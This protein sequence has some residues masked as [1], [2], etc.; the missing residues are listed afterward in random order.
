MKS[1]STRPNQRQIVVAEAEDAVVMVADKE[2][3]ADVVEA[4]AD[5]AEVA[6]VA[7]V[8]AVEAVAAEVDTKKNAR[9]SVP[10]SQQGFRPHLIRGYLKT[11]LN[12]LST[13]I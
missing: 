13:K 9:Q 11:A 10:Y 6:E 4:A 5:V 2:V 8:A 1:R 12:D 7:V 3:A